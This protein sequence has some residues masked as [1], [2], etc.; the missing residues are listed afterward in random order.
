MRKP[1]RPLLLLALAALLSG[2]LTGEALAHIGH[3]AGGW[4]DA[5]AHSF[6]GLEHML[7]LAVALVVAALLGG[8]RLRSFG[9]RRY[10]APANTLG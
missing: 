2:A 10:F 7:A 4:L 5:L 3:H 6:S 1:T 9:A 8:A